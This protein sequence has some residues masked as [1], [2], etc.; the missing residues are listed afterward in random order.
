MLLDSV[1]MCELSEG[2]ICLQWKSKVNSQ[3][4][5]FR[6]LK[7]NLIKSTHTY[8]QGNEVLSPQRLKLVPDQRSV[9]P[10]ESWV[11]CFS[12]FRGILR[13]Q[14]WIQ[15]GNPSSPGLRIIHKNCTHRATG[16]I[17]IK[18]LCALPN[19]GVPAPP[20][21]QQWLPDGPN[22]VCNLLASTI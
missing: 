4:V 8:I 7:Y 14:K 15:P 16:Q 12:S 13:D 2:L 3:N 9:L 20:V 21:S 6:H 1:Q 11:S 19:S 5:N 17:L 22:P 18:E 10:C